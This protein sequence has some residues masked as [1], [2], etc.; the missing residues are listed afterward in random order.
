MRVAIFVIVFLFVAAGSFAASDIPPELLA[1]LKKF[2]EVILSRGGKDKDIQYVHLDTA[3]FSVITGDGSPRADRSGS[4]DF[5][6]KFKGDMV[7]QVSGRDSWRN[8]DARNYYLSFNTP[9]RASQGTGAWLIERLDIFDGEVGFTGWPANPPLKDNPD[10]YYRTLKATATKLPLKV[11]AV[12]FHLDKHGVVNV[13]LVVR[14]TSQK[15]VV[16]IRGDLALFDKMDYPVTW[17]GGRNIFGFMSQDEQIE[18]NS[19]ETIGPWA[20]RLYGKTR[21]MEPR[22]HTLQFEDGTFWKSTDHG[23]KKNGI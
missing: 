12:R 20:L 7:V 1:E 21:K 18:P 8:S 19:I 4:D 2:P 3:T 10:V 13:H 15:T 22:I 9:A 23:K 6:V 14:N 16:G 11:L 17:G 5:F